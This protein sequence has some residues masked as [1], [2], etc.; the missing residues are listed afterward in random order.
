LESGRCIP[1][2]QKD[3][4]AS[5]PAILVD[6]DSFEVSEVRFTTDPDRPYPQPVSLK[7]AEQLGF[8]LSVQEGYDLALYLRSSRVRLVLKARQF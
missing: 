2:E 1:C 4:M 6:R 7:R 8:V 3:I 5:C